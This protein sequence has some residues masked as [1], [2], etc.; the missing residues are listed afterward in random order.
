[1]KKIILLISAVICAV[2]AYAQDTETQQDF[3]KFSE[4]NEH[5]FDTLTPTITGNVIN[6]QAKSAMIMTVGG[7]GFGQY[8]GEPEPLTLKGE[9]KE[10]SYELTEAAW[11]LPYFGEY[12]IYIGVLLL[13]DKGEPIETPE[14]DYLQAEIS[15]KAVTDAPSRFLWTSP[16]GEWSGLNTFEK[17]YTDGEAGFVFTKPVVLPES[18]IGTIYYFLTN[19]KEQEQTITNYTADYNPLDGLY[20]V[21]F[22]IQREGIE[23]NAIASIE[24]ELD[25][26]KNQYGAD[27]EVPVMVLDNTTKISPAPKKVKNN[28]MSLTS[29]QTAQVYSMQGILINNDMPLNEVQNLPKGIY[30]VNGKKVIIK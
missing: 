26:V 14:G 11:G 4:D 5:Q 30:I 15:Y 28:G 29:Q 21:A 25:S 9:N 7:A 16:D 6:E 24:V 19:G 22:S 17:A 12:Y 27:I 8:A 3:V 2:C 10:F 23:A 1:M 20:T 18:P 13:D